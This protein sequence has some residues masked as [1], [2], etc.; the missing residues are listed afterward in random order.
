MTGLM[1]LSIWYGLMAMTTMSDAATTSA[2]LCNGFA[3]TFIVVFSS[4]S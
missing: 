1:T 2:A 3:P 4:L